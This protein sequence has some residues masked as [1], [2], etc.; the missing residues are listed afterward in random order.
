[1]GLVK[2]LM[3]ACH[4]NCTACTLHVQCKTTCI[5]ATWYGRESGAWPQSRLC[6]DHERALYVIGEAPGWNEDQKGEC[7]VGKAGQLLK[8]AYID[9]FK[10]SNRLDI[11]LSN[12][13]RCHPPGNKN[14]TRTQLKMCQ[15]FYLA[16]IVYLQSLYDQVIILCCGAPA[17]QSVLALSLKKSFSRQGDFTDFR[18]LTAPTPKAIVRLGEVVGPFL[19]DPTLPPF[20]RPCPVF[21]TYHPA[22]LGR[23]KNYAPYV[24]SHLKMLSDYIDGDL[25]YEIKGGS[26]KIQMAPMPPTYPLSRL[27]LDIESYGILKGQNQTQFHPLKSMVHDG[28]KKEDLVVTVGLSWPNEKDELEHAIFI[29]SRESHRRRLWSWIKKCRK[30]VGEP[31]GC[32]THQT[33]PNTV[34]EYLIGQNLKFDLMYLRHAYPE[35]KTWLN[36]PLPIVDLMITNYLLNEGRP[37]KSLKALAPLLRV[38]QYKDGFTQYRADTDLV[39]HQYNCQDT[40]ATLLSQEKLEGLIGTLYG[41][42]TPKLSSF[43]REWYTKLLWLTVWMEEAGISMNQQ[44]L[45]GLLKSY[46]ARMVKLERG[47]KNRWDISLRGKGSSLSKRG[48]MDEACRTLLTMNLLVPKLE[49]TAT[50]RDISFKEENRNALL[51]VLPATSS[52][53]RQLRAISTAHTV[54]GTLDRYLYPLLVGRGKG[55]IDP[56][57]RLIEGKIYP[58]WYPV[59]SEWEDGSTGG[60]K[61]CRIVAKGPACQTFPPAIKK[62]IT[63]RYDYL[64]WF[65]YSQIEL[66]IAAL[67]SNDPW[68]MKEFSRPGCDFHLG[69]AAKLFGE[70]DAK[71]MRPVGKELNFLVIYL[72]GA[73]RYQTVLLRKKRI[74]RSRGQCQQDIDAWWLQAKGLKKWQEELYESA[75]TN[76]YI[77]LPLAGQSRTFLGNRWEVREQMKEIVNIPVQATAANVMLSAQFE[78][79][80]AFMQKRMKAVLPINVYDAASIE[81]P[82][83]ELYAVQHEMKR[84]LPDP[85]YYQALCKVL[86]RRLPLEYDVEIQRI[87]A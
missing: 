56:T 87:T 58:R 68:M 78:L 24:S 13:V 66:R 34:F 11:F 5:P 16:D 77:Q 41:D 35:C 39:L 23:D 83:Q 43:N 54:G 64:L 53:A 55:H 50:T 8:T 45:E 21:T 72:G 84:I 17:T 75:C 70:K 86:G 71:K 28:I 48:I 15:G 59:P 52:S 63:S 65:D 26:L 7:W 32:N 6:P 44:A 22:A 80:W 81:F 38:T 31:G 14:P 2:T 82:K 79:Q 36:Y 20:P 33:Q 27:S 37:E 9:Y 76:G 61:Q 46:E 18:A 1:M 40:A 73:A 69:T 85:P 10:F 51:D 4:P 3:A 29:M 49:K 57:T 47:I 67:L 74:V 42:S 62:C 12:A 30:S 19:S 60:T 25:T